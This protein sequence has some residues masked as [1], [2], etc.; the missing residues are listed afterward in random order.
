L[1]AGLAG[2]PFHLD[3]ADLLLADSNL[4]LPNFVKAAATPVWRVTPKSHERQ[5]TCNTN[6]N[7]QIQ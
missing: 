5:T 1:F 2:Q 3:Y 4:L 6:K 7:Q